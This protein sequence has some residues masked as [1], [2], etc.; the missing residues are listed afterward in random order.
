MNILNKYKALSVP[1]KASFW[2]TVCNFILKGISFI[3]VPMFAKYLSPEEYGIVSIYNAY[4]QIFLIFA[5]LELSLGAFQRGFIKY[6]DHIKLYTNSLQVLWSIITLGL[7]IITFIFRDVFIKLTE[8]NIVI[9]TLM[10]TYFLL[11]PAYDCW[12]NE[13]RFNYDYRSV[14]ITTIIFTILTTGISLFCVV[15]IKQTAIVRITSMLVVQVVFCIPFYLKNISIK[16]FFS[17]KR[18]IRSFWSFALS[19]QL[20]LVLHSLSYLILAQSDRIMIGAMVGNSKAALYSVA[21]SLASVV[22][23]FQ[24]SVNQVL[25]PWRY[26]KMESKDYKAISNITSIVVIAIGIIILIFILVVPEI[27]KVLFDPN[28]Y[29]AVWTIPPVTLSVYFMFLYSIFTDIESY[30]YKTKYI[31]Y[32]SIICASINILLN[33]IGIKIFGY[34]ACGYATLISYIFFAVLH[35]CFMKKSCNEVGI[36]GGIINTRIVVLFSSFLTIAIIIITI[37]YTNMFIR[38]SLFILLVALCIWRKNRLISILEMI[39]KEKC[40]KK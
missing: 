8:T 6:K 1:V 12:I 16:S 15:F 11:Q 30:L 26:Q 21:Y 22:I 39:I 13:K 5:T 14:V 28:Y 4:Q 33:Y 38:Y 19:F 17:N 10:F 36:K 27:M 25:K 37:F 24:T 34:I 20:P 2:F 40:N 9:L 29:E 32:V 31:M 23:I 18:A 3:T 35:Y 7:F